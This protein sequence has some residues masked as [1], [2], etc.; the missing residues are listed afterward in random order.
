MS[1]RCAEFSKIAAEIQYT[2]YTGIRIQRNGQWVPN[3]HRILSTQE[4]QSLIDTYA[5][6]QWACGVVVVRDSNNIPINNSVPIANILTNISDD[7]IVVGEI[8]PPN[9]HHTHFLMK[10]TRRIDVVR[11]SILTEIDKM[12]YKIDICKLSTCRVWTGMFMYLLKNPLL[13]FA[14]SENLANLAYTA[15][16]KGMSLRYLHKEKKN[17]KPIVKIINGVIQKYQCVTVE[18]VFKH[19]YEELEEYLHMSSLQATISNC[20]LHYQSATNNFDPK[21]FKYAPFKDPEII[22]R[23]LNFQNINTEEFDLIFWR[24]ITKTNDKKNTIILYGPS[25]SGK[26]CFIRGLLQLVPSGHIVNTSSPFFAEGICGK[27][28]ACWEEPLLMQEQADM[29]KLI[30]EG[31]IVSIAQ[32]FKKPYIHEGCPL[33]I[34]TNHEITRFCTSE[35]I[36][37]ENRSITFNWSNIISSFRGSCSENCIFNRQQ[38]RRSTPCRLSWSASSGNSN[39]ESQIGSFGFGS[40]S[41]ISI[42]RCGRWWCGSH[43]NRPCSYCSGAAKQCSNSRGSRIS[44][45][46]STSGNIRSSTG[47]EAGSARDGIST[48]NSEPILRSIEQSG[49]VGGRNNK[50]VDGGGTDGLGSRR[51]RRNSGTGK[52]LIERQALP[53]GGVGG[54]HSSDTENEETPAWKIC[55]CIIEPLPQDWQAYL[56]YLATKY[57]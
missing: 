17:V 57:E 20:L 32:K 2:T 41:G 14:S 11:R 4:T 12:T 16:E 26:S 15:I 36:A 24:W 13:V 1:T 35:Q 43:N 40:T 51:D 56:A 33:I 9:V 46:T 54:T 10:T 3:G 23:I 53:C 22:H 34:T 8:S 38:Q 47:N 28:I 52:S 55:T 6:S 39:W 48:G 5:L 25:N 7:F 42:S 44:A 19:G 37:I 45:C 49:F 30:A 27:Q 31:S 18:Q 21:S 29:F 50:S